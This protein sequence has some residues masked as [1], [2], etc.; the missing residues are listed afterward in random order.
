MNATVRKVYYLML[1]AL[2]LVNSAAMAIEIEVIG[3]FKNAAL[4]NID[5]QRRLLKAGIESVE[6]VK[7]I[8]ADS[9]GATV[10]HNDEKIELA[11]SGKIT[12]VFEKPTN[13]TVQIVGR[14]NQFKTQGTVNG[15]SVGFLVDTG[16]TIVAMNRHQAEIWVWH[17]N[18]AGFLGLRQRVAWFMRI[19]FLLIQ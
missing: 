2:M 4:V 1:A 7:L 14:N 17:M 13:K 10:V 5:G 16:A 11:L 6:G 3:L 18:A 15:R 8:Q 12:S 9:S 19:K